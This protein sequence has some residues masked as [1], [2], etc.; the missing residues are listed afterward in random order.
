[1]NKLIFKYGYDIQAGAYLKG[2]SALRR[3]KGLDKDTFDSLLNSPIFL[4]AFVTKDCP[5]DVMPFKV[6]QIDVDKAQDYI[7]DYLLPSY[8]WYMNKY[9]LKRPWRKPLDPSNMPCTDSSE[10]PF[11]L[12]K[13]EQR[14]NYGR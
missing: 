13:T 6:S 9:G 4:F 11:Y 8:A 3:S 1:M 5:L 2:L 14:G 12:L 7:N 10:V